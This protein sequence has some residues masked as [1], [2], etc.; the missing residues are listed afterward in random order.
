MS[1]DLKLYNSAPSFTSVPKPSVFASRFYNGVEPASQLPEILFVTSCPPRE[2]GIATYTQDLVHALK[3]QFSNAF[4]CTFCALESDTEIHDYNPKPKYTLNTDQR[5]SFAKVA[6]EINRDKKISTVV[7]QHEFGFFSHK[8]HDFSLFFNSITKPLVFVFH[9][10]LPK[11]NPGLKLKVIDMANAAA[12][13]IVMTQNAAQILMADYGIGPAKIKV[14]PHGTHLASTPNKQALKEK[15]NLVGKK[16]LSTFG[17]LSANKG[18]EVSINALP[19]II[20]KQPEVMFLVLGKT[21]PTVVKHEGEKYRTMLEEKVKALGIGA[22]VK[23]VNEYLPLPILLEYLQ[24]TD[25]YLFTSTDP[26]QAVSGTFSYAMSAGCPIISTPIPHAKEVLSEDTGMFFDFENSSQLAD[27]AILLLT[28]QSLGQ[29]LSLNALHQMAPTAWENVAISHAKFFESLNPSIKL[30]Y[31][32]PLINLKHIK[33][34]TTSTGII[35]FSK[36]G[37]PDIASGYTVDDNARALIA[38]SL[39]YKNNG[40]I[41]LLASINTYLDFLKLCIQ[42]NGIFINYIDKFKRATAQNESENLEDSNGRAVWA[43]GLVVSLRGILPNHLCVDAEDMLEKVLPNLVHVHST[44]SMAFI[45]KGL[46]YQNPQHPLIKTLADRLVQMYRHERTDDWCWFENYLTYGNSVLPEAL[47]C[48][49]FD[50]NN[51]TYKNIA[52][53]AF[54]FLL[55]KIF[56]HEHITVIS[57]K[58][59]LHSNTITEVQVGGEQPID[60]AYTIMA[61]EKFYEVF[62]TNEYRRK[63]IVAFNWFLGENHLHRIVY[64]PCTG[65]CYDGLEEYS[66]NLNQGA[67]ST[68]SYLMARLSIVNIITPGP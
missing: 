42:P 59:W 37:Q 66:V 52:K 39:L 51:A 61:L 12:S 58:G 53:E 44:R 14:I 18:I 65:G 36:I 10:V 7:I 54:D 48:A 9:T 28:K 30:A 21:H 5:N 23:F 43:L 26:N 34:M 31:K 19:A 29:T 47:L 15:Y 8:E 13:L 22:H 35:Q 45:I 41:S 17:L 55:S 24:L 16:I 49:Y 63:A 6:F 57:N 27:A 1:T 33:N 3:N 60:V 50:T 20:K 2:C 4:S 56:I 40:D 64:N 38:M 62:K 11:P 25:I 46:H 68:L 32:I 67:E